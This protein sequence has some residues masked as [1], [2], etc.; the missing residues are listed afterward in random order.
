MAKKLEPRTVALLDYYLTAKLWVDHTGFRD[1]VTWQSTI[2]TG[3]LTES[4]FLR[5]YAWVVLNSGFREAIV[6]KYFNFLSL[7]FCD[8]VSA[9][10]IVENSKG[11]IAAAA[12]VFSHR[13]KLDAI[14]ET[15]RILDHNG[16]PW[17]ISRIDEEGVLFLRSLPFIGAVTSWHLA[18]NIGLDVAKPDRH[19]IRIAATFGYSDVQRMCADIAHETGDRIAV[20][21]VV[22]WRYAVETN[23]HR[24]ACRGSAVR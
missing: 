5:E 11:C 1:E 3:L 7:V 9:K 16:F 17:L 8:W 20:T 10:E 15:A 4:Q 12:Q 19:L 2:N 24:R 21:D 22:L 23:L 14:L 18:K 6:R 13:R